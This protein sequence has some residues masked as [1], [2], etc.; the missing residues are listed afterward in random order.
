MIKKGDKFRCIKTVVM[1]ND[2]N[3]IAYYQGLI[4][5]S[6]NDD[7]TEVSEFCP[8]AYTD[9]RLNV[10]QARFMA[11]MFAVEK[12]M[13]VMNRAYYGRLC[14]VP[15]LADVEHIVSMEPAF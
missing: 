3:N 5:T 1:D 15:S 14:G 12:L 11:E 9:E 10:E 7:C 6:E 13:Q 8:F 2:S 4:Y